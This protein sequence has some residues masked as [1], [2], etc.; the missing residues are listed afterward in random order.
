MK[1]I[2]VNVKIMSWMKWTAQEKDGTWYAYSAKPE[3]WDGGWET[4]WKC[5]VLYKG[6]PSKNWQKTLKKLNG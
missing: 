3:V 6:F 2:N 4:D 1:T 5:S